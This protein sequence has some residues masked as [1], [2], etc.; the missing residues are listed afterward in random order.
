MVCFVVKGIW[1][2]LLR[3]AAST[4]MPVLE[5]V[6]TSC[7]AT[8]VICHPEIVARHDAWYEVGPPQTA[9][10]SCCVFTHAQLLV[11]NP[12]LVR[13]YKR[14]FLFSFFLFAFWTD[15]VL[16]CRPSM[17]PPCFF[18]PRCECLPHAACCNLTRCG[19]PQT[20]SL[21]VRSL[22]DGRKRGFKR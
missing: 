14:V 19:G 11:E 7:F 17:C 16:V 15:G 13:R 21:R 22:L 3:P 8:H 2:H 6:A 10:Y 1:L 5:I 18:H 9:I 20:T 12:G 4:F